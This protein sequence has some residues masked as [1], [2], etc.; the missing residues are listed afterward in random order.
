M[1]GQEA[2]ATYPLSKLKDAVFLVGKWGIS[3]KSLMTVVLGIT[4]CQAKVRVFRVFVRDGTQTRV[5]AVEGKLSLMQLV[6]EEEE[7]PGVGCLIGT[8]LFS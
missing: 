4:D 6:T 5:V 2:Q 1:M 7:C 3:I 8:S